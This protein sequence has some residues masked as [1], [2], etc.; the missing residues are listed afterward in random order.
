LPLAFSVVR[1]ANEHRF[2]VTE[3]DVR[4][5]VSVTAERCDYP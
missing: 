5:F 4:G 3:A 1:G 2:M